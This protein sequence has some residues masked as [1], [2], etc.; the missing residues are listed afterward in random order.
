MALEKDFDVKGITCNYWKILVV[1]TNYAIGVTAITL[2]VYPSKDVRDANADNYHDTKRV[3]LDSVDIVR[4]DMYK[5]IKAQEI[6]E[7]EAVEGE[8]RVNQNFFT[9]ATDIIE[10]VL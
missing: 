1:D 2:G 10:I 8:E 6:F 4:E 7:G 3:V 9:D 5:A